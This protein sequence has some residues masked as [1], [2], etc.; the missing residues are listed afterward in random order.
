MN[1]NHMQRLLDFSSHYRQIKSFYMRYERLL[2]PVTLVVGFLIDYFT[3][4]SIR[5]TT[6]FALLLL[7]WLVLG[8]TIVFIHFFDAGALPQKL[9][10]LRLFAPLAIQFTFGALLGSSLVFYWLSGTLSVSWPIITIVVVLMASNDIFRH[11]FLNPIIQIGIYFFTTL[12]LLSLMLPFMF[13]SL[14]SWVFLLA[15]VLSIGIFYPF[16]VFLLPIKE[17]R[18]KQKMLI[19]IFAV[20]LLMNV[21]YFTNIIPPI[22]LSLR[23]AGLYHGI[24]V[25]RGS[26]IMQGEPETL[27]QR[28]IPGQTVHTKSGEKI[29]LYTAIFAPAKLQTTIVHHW[30]YYDPIKKDWVDRGLL[31]FAIVGGRKEGYK[32]Y[33][34]ESDLEAGAWRIYV[35]NERGQ[36]LGRITFQVKR[37]K[38]KIE[39]KETT[40]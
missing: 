20:L 14:G 40:R 21:L 27:W 22:P 18:V 16:I 19:G 36:V 25:S 12:S 11:Y 6:T 37:V 38:E 2:M 30:Q 35:E 4:T 39:L 28:L 34:F 13:N 32:G 10:Y 23:E 31:S 17:R 8:A 5:L 7:Y 15:G 26:Y 3:F 29:Y 33:S 9:K 1:L 24:M